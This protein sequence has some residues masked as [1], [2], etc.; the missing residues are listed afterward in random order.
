MMKVIKT[1][2]SDIMT[3][4]MS[5]L[6]VLATIGAKRNWTRVKLLRV[7]LAGEICSLLSIAITLEA[8]LVISAGLYLGI[9]CCCYFYERDD[10]LLKR[11]VI[12]WW[13]FWGLTLMT[14]G[15]MVA[16]T[17]GVVASM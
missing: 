4:V 13:F 1:L 14:F 2:M 10:E 15:M 3:F 7:P 16:G 6:L 9:V 17:L 12:P 11:G 8:L 5:I